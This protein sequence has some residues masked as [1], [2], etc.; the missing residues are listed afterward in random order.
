MRAVDEICEKYNLNYNEIAYVGDDVNDIEV[1]NTVGF[2]C[3]VNDAMQ[4]VKD[5]ANYVTRAKGGQGAV[6][7]VIELIINAKNGT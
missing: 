2:G 5:A 6:R 4:S 3:A 7:E 1:I